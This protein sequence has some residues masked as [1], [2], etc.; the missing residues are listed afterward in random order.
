MISRCLLVAGL[1]RIHWNCDPDWT[2]PTAVLLVP[3][4]DGHDARSH[5]S[6]VEGCPAAIW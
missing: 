4:A 2:R 6:L 1:T 5:E 3:P